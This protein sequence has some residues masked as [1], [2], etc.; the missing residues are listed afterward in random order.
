M[1]PFQ[2]SALKTIKSDKIVKHITRFSQNSIKLYMFK[3][4]T[5]SLCKEIQPNTVITNI[6]GLTIFVH[7]NQEAHFKHNF[8]KSLILN[9]NFSSKKAKFGVWMHQKA[10][11][12]KM[13]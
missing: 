11:L 9:K 4:S 1:L 12:K 2:N 10:N 8:R 3:I 6:S 7:Y 5:C 13:T